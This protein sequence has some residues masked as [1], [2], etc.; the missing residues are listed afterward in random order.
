MCIYRSACYCSVTY[1]IGPVLCFL[2]EGGFTG[3]MFKHTVCVNIHVP[4]PAFFVQEGGGGSFDTCRY[5]RIYQVDGQNQAVYYVHMYIGIGR[6]DWL[7]L[8][9]I[10]I[11]LYYPMLPHTYKL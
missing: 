6:G 4:W 5:I 3:R 1:Y 11:L 9:L 2:F 8:I 10:V 7:K